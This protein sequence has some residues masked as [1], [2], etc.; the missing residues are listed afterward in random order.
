MK[1]DPDARLEHHG[2]LLV[3]RTDFSR[4]L[5]A[6]RCFCGA[7]AHSGDVER[8]LPL[9]QAV[10]QGEKWIENC[11]EGKNCGCLAWLSS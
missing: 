4:Q 8:P 10:P 6:L 11:D 3:S 7:P 5:R 1:N 2:G 9:V